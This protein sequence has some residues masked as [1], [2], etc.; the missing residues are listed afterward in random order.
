MPFVNL[1]PQLAKVTYV[2]R[3]GDEPHVMDLLPFVKSVYSPELDSTEHQ[4]ERGAVYQ[5]L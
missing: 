5:A 4:A 3:F 1:S 2:I